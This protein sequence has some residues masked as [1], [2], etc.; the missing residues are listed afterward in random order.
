MND[1]PP[2]I[3][4]YDVNVVQFQ[5]RR[6]SAFPGKRIPAVAA[7]NI[8]KLLSLARYEGRGD[9][10]FQKESPEDFGRRMRANIAA[11]VFVVLLAGLAAVDVIKLEQRQ[12]VP[13][14]AA[15]SLSPLIST[16]SSDF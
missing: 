8:Y 4:N 1:T 14:A 6:V 2:T 11:F 10:N 5:P 15:I 7:G 16:N 9:G 13:S 12:I 3:A